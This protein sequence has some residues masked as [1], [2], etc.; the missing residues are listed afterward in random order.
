MPAPGL[1]R[2][3][4]DCTADDIVEVNERD[5]GV[6]VDG[7]LSPETLDRFNAELEPLL[8]AHR[9][10]DSGSE[11]S[12]DFLG[13]RTRRLQGL[14]TKAPTFV[15]IMLDDRIVGFAEAVLGPISPTIILNDGEVIDIGPGESAQPLHRDDDAW[16]FAKA[17]SPMI[18]NTIAALV[19]V[20]HE[21]GGTLVVPGSHRWDL[22]RQPTA[23]EITACDLPAGSTLFFRGDTLH[24]GGANLTRNSRRRALSTGFC[25][26]WL[27]PVENSY[28][29]VPAEAA[30]A[31]PQ[32]AQEL[33][34]YAL[35]DASEVG[36]GYLGYHDMGDPMK[37][38]A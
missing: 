30:A 20:T 18:V 8:A 6:I 34:G 2:L 26:G 5:G 14:A 22:D 27:R 37:L 15:E 32:R 17:G 35:Y 21:M 31:L 9:G 10:T 11:A 16:N 4:S 7:W 3:P 12:D 28:T 24:A 13:L 23:D 38:F 19:D 33:L 25:C 1:Q 29:N 36:G